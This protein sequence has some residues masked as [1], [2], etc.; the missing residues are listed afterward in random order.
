MKKKFQRF[1]SLTY[2]AFFFTSG[3]TSPL[4]ITIDNAKFATHTNSELTSPRTHA[5]FPLSGVEIEHSSSS[6]FLLFFIHFFIFM[7]IIL[8][9]TS[10]SIQ[11]D[12]NIK[13]LPSIWPATEVAKKYWTS[14]SPIFYLIGFKYDI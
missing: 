4:S 2:A 5:L 10:L 1:C 9:Y 14:I 8:S 3:F 11:N 13:G 12:R 6:F 7:G